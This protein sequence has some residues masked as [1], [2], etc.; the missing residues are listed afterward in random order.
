MKISIIVPVYNIE[1]YL[2]RCLDSIIAQTYQK[3][4]IIVVNDGSTDRSG[5]V[6][7]TYADKDKRIIPIH[8]PN[9]G[10]T[11]ARLTGV[12][13]ATGEYIGFVDG[14][15]VIEPEMYAVLIENA[16]KYNADIS[17]CGYQMVFPN[18][19]DY[20]Y[21]TGRFM[22]Q[23]HEEGLKGLL[24]GEFIEPG[25]WNKLFHKSLF[26]KLLNSDVMDKTIKNTED[27]LMN[28]YLFRE[29]ETS[30]F[31]DK[32]YYH[33]I[34]RKSSAA[35]KDLNEHQLI[36]PIKVTRILLKENQ[37]NPCLS[38]IL[39]SKLARQLISLAT[40]GTKQNPEL[41][42]PK[43]KEARKELKKRS[44]EFLSCDTTSKK[45]KIMIIV[46]AVFPDFYMWIHRLYACLT[47]IDKKYF[48]E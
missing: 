45:L 44:K 18:R 31:I 14:D 32:C 34:V 33:Y 11:N 46:A 10:V 30:V 9:G 40:M 36:D 7:D 13:N 37:T 28:Y 19:V 22:Q 4:E 39:L 21:N 27:L 2:G 20:Y 6:L 24:S 16:V 43:R 48:I 17:H 25:L 8:I 23:D 38:G 5:E 41:I 15:D 29:A 1:E 35:N 42:I 47:G 26:E 12:K 3:L